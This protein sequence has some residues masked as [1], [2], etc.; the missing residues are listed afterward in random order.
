MNLIVN[1]ITYGL[2]KS[3]FCNKLMQEWVNNNDILMYSPHNEGKLV[4][5]KRFIKH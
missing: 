4:I 1:Q 3:E 5:T 2:I